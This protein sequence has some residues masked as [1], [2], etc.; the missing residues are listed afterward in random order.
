M[1]L[2]QMEQL[3][4]LHAAVTYSIKELHTVNRIMNTATVA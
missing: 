2:S 1:V 4:T 3:A